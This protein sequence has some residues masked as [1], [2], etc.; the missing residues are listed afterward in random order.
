MGDVARGITATIPSGAQP[1][2]VFPKCCICGAMLGLQHQPFEW[3]VERLA[4]RA[5]K[6]LDGDGHEGGRKVVV[7]TSGMGRPW[8]EAIAASPAMFDVLP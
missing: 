4:G 5:M 6:R 1:A 8:V 7:P 3:V 2:A